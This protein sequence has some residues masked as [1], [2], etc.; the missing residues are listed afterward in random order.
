EIRLTDYGRWSRIDEYELSDDGRWLVVT[1]QLERPPIRVDIYDLLTNQRTAR[2]L[3]GFGGEFRWTAF[4]TLYQRFGCGTGCARL[5]IYDTSGH[6]LFE[7]MPDDTTV[8]IAPSEMYAAVYVLELSKPAPV[9]IISLSDG[10]TIWTSKRLQ[11][12]GNLEW[13]GDGKLSF[14]FGDEDF[15]SPPRTFRFRP[16]GEEDQQVRSPACRR[17]KR[18]GMHRG[19][20]KT[21]EDAWKERLKDQSR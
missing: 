12:V 20:P 2:F 7:T 1:F 16:S 5:R 13:A 6:I 4:N 15:K 18:Y 21:F 3:P 8:D 10:S 9:A 19:S 14:S 11:Y 17:I